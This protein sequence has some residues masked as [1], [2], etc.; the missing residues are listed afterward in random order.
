MKDGTYIR[1]LRNEAQRPEEIMKLQNSLRA[2]Q[3]IIQSTL[4]E[5]PD[6]TEELSKVLDYL[7]VSKELS[8][9]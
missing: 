3:V 9:K 5:Y 8:P 6:L 4:N 2:I 7:L 1:A